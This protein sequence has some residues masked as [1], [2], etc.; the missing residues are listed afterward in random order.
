[1]SKLTAEI[2]KAIRFHVQASKT[3][4]PYE[5]ENHSRAAEKLGRLL[6]DVAHH[7][8]QQGD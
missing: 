1:V 7:D 4:V 8:T 5:M 2:R 6:I 3:P